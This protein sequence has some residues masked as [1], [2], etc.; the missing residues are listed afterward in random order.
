MVACAP[1]TASAHVPWVETTKG[2]GPY[3]VP[4]PDVSRALYGHLDGRTERLRFTVDEPVNTRLELLVPARA[5]DGFRP[6]VVVSGGGQRWQAGP[7]PLPQE[8]FVEPFSLSAF[9]RSGSVQLSLKPG[10]RYDIAVDARGSQRSGPFVLA[11]GGAEAFGGDDIVETARV[12]PTIWLGTWGGQSL[13]PGASWSLAVLFTIA[14]LGLVGWF[15][16][17]TTTQTSRELP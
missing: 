13:R 2:F 4:G 12:L 1:V 14:L 7:D 9:R 15:L 5:D 11:F 17:A 16:V 10:V 6:L 3:T 8:S